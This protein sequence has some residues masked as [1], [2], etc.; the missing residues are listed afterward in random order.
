MTKFASAYFLLR[1]GADGRDVLFYHM[2]NDVDGGCGHTQVV[3]NDKVVHILA[4]MAKDV[5]P[6]SRDDRLQCVSFCAGHFIPKQ[7]LD[8]LDDLV[9]R[10]GQVLLKHFVRLCQH[11][12][13]T[14]L[15]PVVKHACRMVHRHYE[16]AWRVEED[17]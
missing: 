7:Q 11:H 3:G 17:A 9:R 2:A 14:E 16:V 1:T 12:S 10:V 6:L 15:P 13:R 5:R 4:L 8:F